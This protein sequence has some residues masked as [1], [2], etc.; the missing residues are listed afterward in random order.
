MDE[1]KSRS[2]LTSNNDINAQAQSIVTRLGRL[3]N[4]DAPQT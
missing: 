3:L 1:A 2:A 4:K